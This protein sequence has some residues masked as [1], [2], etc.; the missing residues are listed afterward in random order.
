MICSTPVC[1]LGEYIPEAGSNTKMIYYR[2]GLRSLQ[3]QW[4]H[5]SIL[6]DLQPKAMT[7][8]IFAIFN[9][10][11]ITNGSLTRRATSSYRLVYLFSCEQQEWN[12]KHKAIL[13]TCSL[14]VGLWE[15]SKREIELSPLGVP[16]LPSSRPPQQDL[17]RSLDPT[18]GT[19]VLNGLS[20]CCISESHMATGITESTC[21]EALARDTF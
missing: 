4:L 16:T 6:S 20:N 19:T 3:H 21:S 11:R 14:H 17:W 10:V 1:S 8:F 12:T 9:A 7:V 5:K 2:N 18:L 13:P 15:M